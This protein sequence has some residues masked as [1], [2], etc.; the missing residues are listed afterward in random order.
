MFIEA[1]ALYRL[2]WLNRKW[3]TYDNAESYSFSGLRTE[4]QHVAA[5]RLLWGGRTNLLRIGRSTALALEGFAGIG[6]RWKQLSFITHEGE[7]LRFDPPRECEPCIEQ[8]S[9]GTPSVHLGIRLAFFR[10][11]RV[12]ENRPSENP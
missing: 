5:I 10:E 8:R 11:R 12:A 4:R 2:W 9:F 1:D 7:L 3:I 6:A